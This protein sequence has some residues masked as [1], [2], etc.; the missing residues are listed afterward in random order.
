MI[1]AV[2]SL[3]AD[4]SVVDAPNLPYHPPSV[5]VPAAQCACAEETL[6]FIK[7]A[8]CENKHN[9]KSATRV[10]FRFSI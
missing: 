8:D 9:Y 3:I 7:R 6:V 2:D 5:S 10:V 1:S 4:V